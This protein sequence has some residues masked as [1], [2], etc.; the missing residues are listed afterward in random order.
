MPCHPTP[1]HATPCH[2]TTTR[3]FHSPDPIHPVAC[4]ELPYKGAESPQGQQLLKGRGQVLWAS[5]VVT[6]SL[7]SAFSSLFPPLPPPRPSP[8]TTSELRFKGPESPQGKQL[9]GQVPWAGMTALARLTAL[10][11]SFNQASGPPVTPAV[12]TFTAL[13]AL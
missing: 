1:C 9:Q 12:S 10:D 5:M 6:L 8:P 2:A 7:L 4:S 3:L 13:Q 11:L